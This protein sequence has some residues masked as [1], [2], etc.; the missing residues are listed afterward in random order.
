VPATGTS[1]TAAP[2]PAEPTPGHDDD[3]APAAS[4]AATTSPH[5]DK[6]PNATAG[7]PTL[8]ASSS[9]D[10]H[11]AA[12]GAAAP[13]GHPET[14]TAAD[15]HRRRRRATAADHHAPHVHRGRSGGHRTPDEPSRD[16]GETSLGLDDPGAGDGRGRRG[17]KGGTPP[18]KTRWRTTATT[19]TLL[20]A[21]REN[22][23]VV[24]VNVSTWVLLSGVT[25]GR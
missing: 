13:G 2:P 4:V 11:G 15:H 21:V 22:E 8:A 3:R 5:D 14:T 10:D 16:G 24:P 18:L 25:V 9:L 17:G 7:A 6:A 20:A 19:A 23:E 1:V 12:T